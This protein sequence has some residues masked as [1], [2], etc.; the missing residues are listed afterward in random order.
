MASGRKQLVSFISQKEN[1]RYV[2]TNMQ[3]LSHLVSL[4]SISF[5]VPQVDLN[6]DTM[7]REDKILDA[8]EQLTSSFN[9]KLPEQ[10]A[11]VT[12]KEKMMQG[13]QVMQIMS[14]K[15]QN[16]YGAEIF[17]VGYVPSVSSPM[18]HGVSQA[19]DT[20]RRLQRR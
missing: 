14:V 11:A 12:E 8:I 10:N 18:R 16:K 9:V 1:L 19:F 15:V 17:Q 6:V 7:S 3:C 20:T 4:V 13:L 2:L 5:A